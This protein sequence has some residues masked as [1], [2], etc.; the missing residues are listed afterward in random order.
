MSLKDTADQLDAYV[1]SD[2]EQLAELAA[3]V[4]A[5]GHDFRIEDGVFVPTTAPQGK[6][7]D[8]EIDIGTDHFRIGV[9]SD[10]H[11]GS[12]HEQNSALQHFYRY[13]DGLVPNPNG[14]PPIEPVD[15]F[16]NGGDW[17]QGPDRMHRDQP[18]SVHVHGADQQVDY[19]VRS[20][21]K[22]SRPGVK[23]YGISG[24]HDA[25]YLGDGG[26]NVFRMIAERRED[27]VYVGQDA[28]YLT[29]GKLKIYLVHP[30]GGGSY[31]KSYKGQRGAEALPIS[32]K[33]NLLLRGH[34]HSFDWVEEHGIQVIMLPCFQSQYQW[35]ARKDLHPD[36]G[37]L[38]LDVWM[39]HR[40]EVGR[41]TVERVRYQARDNDWDHR[42]SNAVVKSW[43]PKGLALP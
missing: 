10:T 37:G 18:Y 41:L 38:I 32:R 23:T 13:A 26:V 19:V 5:A 34:Y 27:I 4:H 9:V 7:R 21:P 30:Q 31:A 39:T 17:T 20:Y 28:Q 29:I 22:S 40:G 43:S 42:A 3:K 25:S 8:L 1:K 24:N 36:I 16:I 11:G 12:L 6:N 35:L 15:A 33:V 14:F 2:L